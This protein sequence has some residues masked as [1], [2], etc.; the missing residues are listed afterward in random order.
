M[1]RGQGVITAT[2][3]LVLALAFFFLSTTAPSAIRVYLIGACTIPFGLM[4]VSLI[5]G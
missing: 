5:K 3:F 4:V 1:R 2:L